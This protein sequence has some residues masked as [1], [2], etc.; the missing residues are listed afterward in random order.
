MNN[1][2]PNDKIITILTGPSFITSDDWHRTQELATFQ[3]RQ[4]F[5]L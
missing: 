5:Q 3:P 4:Y 2:E 1:N